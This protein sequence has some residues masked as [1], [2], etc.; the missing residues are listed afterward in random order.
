MPSAAPLVEP[1]RARFPWWGGDLQ[2]VA[3]RFSPARDELAAQGERLTFALPDGTGDT[4]L[5]MLHRP[6]TAT[7]KP[8]AILIHGLTGCETSAY[9]AASA[10]HLLGLGYPVLR[11][12]LRGAG[13]SRAL[14][15]EQYYAGRSNDFRLLLSLLPP[16]LTANGIVAIGYSLG[17]AMLLKYLGEEGGASSLRAA[18]SVCAPIDLAHTCIHMMRARNKLYHR[19]ILGLMQLEATGA[20]AS[21]TERERG[22]ILASRT[23]WEYD[24][25]YIAPRYGFAD[26]ADYYERCKPARF[27]PAIRTP[28][29]VVAAA[30]DP[31]VPSGLY[32]AFDWSAAQALTPLIADGGGHVGF[33]ARGSRVAWHDRALATFFERLC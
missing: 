16:A 15:G 8:L 21:I 13:P 17:G 9:V 24:D 23:V 26:A 7:S 2:T 12:N 6:A 30:D 33:H 19:Y 22:A 29:L 11:L 32:R 28:T 18:A 25:V 14:C 27:M 1:F 5:G 10:R 3:S 31:W 20:G 4:M